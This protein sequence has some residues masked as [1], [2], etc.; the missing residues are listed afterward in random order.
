MLD[1]GRDEWCGI[2][3]PL[4]AV[5]YEHSVKFLSPNWLG[6]PI[7]KSELFELMLSVMECGSYDGW[8]PD[9]RFFKCMSLG[10]LLS[11]TTYLLISHISYV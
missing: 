5:R 3:F 10:L 1:G 6:V 9:N 7:K 8:L 11:Q 2:S 4:E